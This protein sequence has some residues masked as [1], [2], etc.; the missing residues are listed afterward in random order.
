M[1]ILFAASC[2]CFI[3]CCICSGQ[4]HQ[5]RPLPVIAQNRVGVHATYLRGIAAF[6]PLFCACDQGNDLLPRFAGDSQRPAHSIWAEYSS[7]MRKYTFS[8]GSVECSP[9]DC[10]ICSQHNHPS[11]NPDYFFTLPKHRISAPA[12]TSNTFSDVEVAMNFRNVPIVLL[13][14]V[15]PFLEDLP[16][17]RRRST[18]ISNGIIF[19]FCNAIGC[20]RTTEMFL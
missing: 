4:V 11:Q 18:E 10:S 12:R 17:V 1:D 14:R 2:D 3:D 16:V 6:F 15:T 5:R 20:Y 8:F 13:R 7:R 9:P 19:T